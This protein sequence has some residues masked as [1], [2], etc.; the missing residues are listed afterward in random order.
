[1]G[2]LLNSQWQEWT[3]LK[4]ANSSRYPGLVSS[5]CSLSTV[6]KGRNDTDFCF[7]DMNGASGPTLRLHFTVREQWSCSKVL[8]CKPMITNNISLLCTVI[9][10]CH[11]YQSYDQRYLQHLCQRRV[12]LKNWEI[13]ISELIYLLQFFLF[14]GTSIWYSLLEYPYIYCIFLLE[15]RE[16]H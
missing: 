5:V 8:H 1:M 16:S 9:T 6:F 7:Q 15:N 10:P 2:H 14:S 13:N 12:E 3:T 4:Y 11:H